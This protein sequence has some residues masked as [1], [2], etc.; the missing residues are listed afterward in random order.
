MHRGIG[1]GSSLEWPRG[2]IVRADR[3]RFPFARL[4]IGFCIES[5]LREVRSPAFFWIES[6]S[7]SE[8][9]RPNGVPR[10]PVAMVK[11]WKTQ[12]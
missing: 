11:T 12:T 2:L 5:F 3:V 6:A 10:F 1:F 9:R 8:P 7:T 4:Q